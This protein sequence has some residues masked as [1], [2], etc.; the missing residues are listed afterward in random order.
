MGIVYLLGDFGKE[1]VYK[2]GVTKG[3]IEKRIKQLQTGNSG[4]I[5]LVDYFKTE[6]PFFIE[7]S[8]HFKYCPKKKK[9]EWFELGLEDIS[10]FQ[11]DCLIIEGNA[12]ILKENHFAKKILK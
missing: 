10:N 9:N 5:Y 3:E 2:I 4:E 6:Y 8:L 12:K 1:N 11:T 7:R